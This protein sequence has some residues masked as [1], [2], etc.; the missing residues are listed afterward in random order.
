MHGCDRL[1]FGSR[2][3][4]ASWQFQPLDSQCE[5]PTK[6][7]PDFVQISC[8]LSTRSFANFTPS[9]CLPPEQSLIFM[10]Y[11]Y[12][13]VTLK[14]SINQLI[15]HRKRV[16]GASMSLTI[17]ECGFRHN[18]VFIN[19]HYIIMFSRVFCS[20]DNLVMRRRRRLSLRKR[21]YLPEVTLVGT[22]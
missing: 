9:I 15:Q 7:M 16:I 6:E 20:S 18:I 11:C 21:K 12:F 10:C 1:Y 17:G 2:V 22:R 3:L 4:L 13:C 19:S 8:Q 5:D 14:I